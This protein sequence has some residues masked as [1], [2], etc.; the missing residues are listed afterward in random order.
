MI[1]NALDKQ[2]TSQDTLSS[3]KARLRIN[4]KVVHVYYG[5]ATEEL[6]RDI[7]DESASSATPVRIIVKGID[8]VEEKADL[9]NSLADQLNDGSASIRFKHAREGSLILHVT[10]LNRVLQ[11]QKTLNFEL[12]NFLERVFRIGNIVERN[13]VAE[14]NIILTVEE[15]GFEF[16]DLEITEEVYS[17]PDGKHSLLLDLE[18]SND[19]LRTD[20]IFQESIGGFLENILTKTNGKQLFPEKEVTAIVLPGGN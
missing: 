20:D 17:S 18:V 10:I 14:V 7:K 19:M 15:D 1:Y 8:S 4:E 2:Q 11:H 16:D 6:I 9:L 12:T 5:K 3:K 13:A